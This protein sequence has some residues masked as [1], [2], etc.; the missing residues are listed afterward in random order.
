M[1][2][3]A[4][5][6]AARGD[7]NR[8]QTLVRGL[9]PRT[10]YLR[11]FNGV[12]ELS[13]P[14]LERFSRADPQGNYTLLAIAPDT[15]SAVGM[16]QYSADPYPDRCDFALLVADGWQGM[17]IGRQLLRAL[18]GFARRAGFERIEGEVLAENQPMLRL[19]QSMGFR[20]RRDPQS[21]LLIHA[22][23]SFVT[24]NFGAETAAT[25]PTPSIRVHPRH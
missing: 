13:H 21:A 4:L 19:A 12:Q 6:P 5:R 11:F 22:G 3:I 7:Q 10:R 18:I 15:G 8:I 2:A 9:T 23:I 14:W 16:A 25:S 17:G 24:H 20:L 1:N